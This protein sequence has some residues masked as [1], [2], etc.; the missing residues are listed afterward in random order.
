MLIG[1]MR[2]YQDDENCEQQF[3]ILTDKSCHKIISEAHVS[4]KRR[5]KL[6]DVLS[7]LQK[8]D[9]IIIN[10]LYAI[11]DSTRHLVE[12]LD[13][14]ETSGAS[15][16]SIEEGVDTSD[17]NGYSFPHVV[18]QLAMFQSD[19]K[20]EKTKR[21]KMNAKKKRASVGRAR[22]P[23]KNVRRDID[24]YQSKNY[25]LAEIRKETGI[26][27]STL[28]R[29]LESEFTIHKKQIN[30]YHGKIGLLIIT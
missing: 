2:P 15:L 20:R 16:Q 30:P 21:G 14:I 12:L 23:D 17:G 28:Y 19:E 5:E 18:K 7:S 27:K 22:K 10:K 25:T 4:A 11:A 6:E 1:Y 8:G 24:M 13:R 29:Y 26:S 9:E 3:K